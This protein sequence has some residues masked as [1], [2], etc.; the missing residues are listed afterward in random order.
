MQDRDG[1]AEAAAGPAEVR[2]YPRLGRAPESCQGD[3]DRRR[4][5]GG[6]LVPGSAL[7][8]SSSGGPQATTELKMRTIGGFSAHVHFYCTVQ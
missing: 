6:W 2:E 5:G 1:R 3:G 7:L 4:G 8:S